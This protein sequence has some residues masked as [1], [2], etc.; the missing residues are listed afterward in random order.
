M[1]E[2]LQ[3]I[4]ITGNVG[5][6][7]ESKLVAGKKVI[8]FSVAVNKS[9]KQPDGT[10]TKTTN[11]Y[12]VDCWGENMPFGLD[13]GVSVTV[14]GEFDLARD[15]GTGKVMIKE[16]GEPL[17]KVRTSSALVVVHKKSD[18]VAGD[19]PADASTPAGTS[20]EAPSGYDPNEDLPF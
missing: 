9:R 6:E 15:K 17:L 7:P 14:I 4:I 11:W 19:S 20:S 13:K 16:S 5:R 18:R 2:A 3:Q 1:A 8:S 12:S 10:W